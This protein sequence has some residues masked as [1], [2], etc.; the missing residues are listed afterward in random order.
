[1]H[2]MMRLASETQSRTCRPP[3]EMNRLPASPSHPGIPSWA[4]SCA[5]TELN[6][7]IQVLTARCKIANIRRIAQMDIE[8]QFQTYFLYILIMDGCAANRYTFI[9]Y[10]QIIK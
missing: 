6:K 3:E 8:K 1:M 7:V 4:L 9:V 2:L 5:I 10:D